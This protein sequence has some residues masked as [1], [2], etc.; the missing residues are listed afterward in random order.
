MIDVLLIVV[1]DMAS[2][3]ERAGQRDRMR[4][5]D[6]LDAAAEVRSV[7]F[8]LTPREELQRAADVV[9]EILGTGP[10]QALQ[11]LIARYPHVRRFLPAL[12]DRVRFAAV[13][14]HHPVIA[15][16]DHLRAMEEGTE[17]VDDA[18]RAVITDA[19]RPLVIVEGHVDR[20]GYTLCV[21]D[22]LRL[23]LR[24]RDVYVVGADR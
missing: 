9:A 18:P 2:R 21:L 4:T 20:R 11:R 13:T 16:L 14:S 8:A 1:H 19:W 23:A 12:L 22:R 10:D 3:S 15:A 24:R 7:V 5:L 17:G 6:Q